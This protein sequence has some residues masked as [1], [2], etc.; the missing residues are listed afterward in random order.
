MI[1]SPGLQYIARSLPHLL[2]PCV[3][4]YGTLTVISDVLAIP[5][6]RWALLSLVAGLRL[7]HLYLRPFLIN[8]K[9]ARYAKA[10]G[11]VL[12]PQIDVG[13][14]EVPKQ[15]IENGKNGYIAGNF[16]EWS[17][18][19]GNT[20]RLRVGLD[21][22][23]FTTEPEHVKAI[24]ATQFDSFDKGPQTFAQFKSLLG[25][26]VFNSDGDMWKF[27]RSITR[28]FFSKE[29]ISDFDVFDRH[30]EEAIKQA[31]DR[32]AQGYPIDFQDLVSRFTLDSATEFLFKNDVH[33]LAAGLPYP[34]HPSPLAKPNTLT[35]ENH[36]SNAFV[37]AF[38]G[39]QDLTALRGR[40][41]SFWALKEMW[42]DVV[43]PLRKEVDRF[44]E[45]FLEIGA[46][47]KDESEKTSKAGVDET[48][49]DYLVKQTSDR[50]VIK[51]ELV[52][53]LVASRDTT[54]SLL[55][56]SL[57]ML[58]ENPEITRRLREEIISLVGTNSRPTYDDI[59]DMKY[60]RAFL[61]EVLRLYPSVPGNARTAMQPV[62]LSPPAGSDSS[63]YVPAG[64]RVIY[65]VFLMHRRTDLW[66]P[67][68]LKFDP[69]RFLD[70]RLQKYL[71]KNPFIFTPFNAGPRIC[72]G[73]QFAYNEA[74]FFLIRLLQQF[75]S[76]SLAVDAQ[77]PQ[78][79]APKE[80]AGV[81]G[82]QGRDRIRLAA[83]LTMYVKGG[84]WVRM[85]QANESD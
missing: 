51:D 14:F 37:R 82:P 25:T 60:L 6:P 35:F 3:I 46:T 72:L 78:S 40:A 22:R 4:G 26:G 41:G 64:T 67:D 20:Y 31:K 50:Q 21:E 16:L 83:H 7:A 44:V 69:D 43:A 17:R 9:N 49:L 18:K 81:E 12:P 28:P 63:I 19:F 52:N 38:V 29:R 2:L 79:L 77:P 30:A 54:A 73:Q 65:S 59:R 36:P 76:F 70:E 58:I 85:E 8:R 34:D 48:L 62:V 84:L 42:G 10:Y 15:L 57:Y 55:S 33:S 32:L 71:V 74:S 47:R 13:P 24:L 75:S 66:G 39:G 61:N 68:A 53:L 27:H 56:F 5:V 45:P 23:Y 80:W 11:A 1:S